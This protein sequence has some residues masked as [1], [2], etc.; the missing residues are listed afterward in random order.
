[1]PPALGNVSLPAW[2]DELAPDGGIP[3]PQRFIGAGGG[4][5][6]VDWL[7]VMAWYLH[8]LAER[9]HE[10]RNGPIHSY[11]GGLR[12]WDAR[13]WDRAWV[14]RIALFLRRWSE[15]LH[16]GICGPLPE[17]EVC[18]THDLDAIGITYAIRCK[19]TAFQLLNACRSACSCDGRRLRDRLASARRFAFVRNGRDGLCETITLE[20]SLGLRSRIHVYGGRGGWLRSPLDLV[21][22]PGYNLAHD[23]ALAR[24]LRCLQGDGWRIGIHPSF[25]AWSSAKRIAAEMRRITETTGID[26][27]CSRNHWLRFSFGASWRLLGEAGIQEDS[28]L[29]FNDRP[30]F[31]CGAALRFQPLDLATG[32]P[33][34]LRVLP[35]I[36]MDSQLYDY[37][38]MCPEARRASMARWLD[39]VSAVRGQAAVLWHPHTLGRAYGWDDGF[40][41]L[42]PM[43]ARMRTL[44]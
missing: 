4:W 18:L 3:T 20:R 5:R 13:L 26:V 27:D 32:R 12:G 34:P 35:L 25:R 43:V 40:R 21:L 17:A 16:P 36:L 7:S 23:H 28:T 9:A 33:G 10:E 39:E 42:L 31:R 2:A 8:S 37:S 22:D 29:G 1:M 41:Q 30:G 38:D 19:Q 24:R 44:V 14:N 6:H 15:R 11:A